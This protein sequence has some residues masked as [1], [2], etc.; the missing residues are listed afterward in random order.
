MT[1]PP[2]R[3]GVLGAARIAP[4]AILAP[5]RIVDAV[6]EG[7]I[8]LEIVWG[9]LAGYFAK[10]STVPLAVRPVQPQVDSPGLPFAYDISVGVR[11]GD[12]TLR[13]RIQGVLV[14]RAD[15]ID[16]ILRDFGVPR[17]EGLQ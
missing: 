15:G 10:R 3:I 17:A 1:E 13:D 2:L 12:T 9:P 7:A 6:A 5:A 8:D 14:R 4:F 11:R 16:A